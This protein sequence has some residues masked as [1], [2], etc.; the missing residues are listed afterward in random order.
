[1]PKTIHRPETRVLIEL[2]RDFRREAGLTQVQLSTRIGRVQSFVSDVEQGQ[3]RLD[4]IQL[5]DICRAMSVDLP[6]FIAAF[7]E[8]LD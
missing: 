4:L 6:T 5:R 8:R 1:M 7:E 3:R 2:I